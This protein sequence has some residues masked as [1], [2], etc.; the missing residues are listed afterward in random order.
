GVAAV[1]RVRRGTAVH[2][3]RRRAAQPAVGSVLCGARRVVLRVRARGAV[4]QGGGA[5]DA[6]R[7]A[8]AHAR[9]PRQV[10]QRRVARGAQ[11]DAGHERQ[12]GAAHG[13]QGLV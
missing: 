5:D 9:V 6:A 7:E 10:W 8:A 13:A 11:A 3:A 12:H 2:G 1:E 4:R